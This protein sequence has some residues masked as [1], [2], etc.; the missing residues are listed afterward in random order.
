[1]HGE[2]VRWE[3]VFEVVPNSTGH[4]QK[5]SFSVTLVEFMVGIRL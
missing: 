5:K 2:I 1:M 3:H 4:S